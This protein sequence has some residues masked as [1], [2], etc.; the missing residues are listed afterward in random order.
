M[1]TV[2]SLQG[3]W[4]RS[5]IRRPGQ[6]DDTTTSVYWFQGEERYIDIR[7][8]AGAPDFSGVSRLEELTL[9]HCLWLAD[10]EAFAGRLIADGQYFEWIRDVDF[11]PRAPQPDSGSLHW[12][13]DILVERGRYADYIEHWRRDPDDLDTSY[14]LYVRD[15]WAFL[16]QHLSL[17]QQVA[18]AKSLQQA[19]ALIDCEISFGIDGMIIASSLPFRVGQPCTCP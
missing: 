18:E 4:R 9:E 8:S 1:L 10:Q 16:R 14:T 15:R 6:P 7:Q 11:Q 2:A 13:G 5:L 17:R 19:Q 3:L 12:E